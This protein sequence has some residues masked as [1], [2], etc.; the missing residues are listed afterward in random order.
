MK[1][2]I[3]SIQLAKLKLVRWKE[4]IGR[5][6]DKEFLEKSLLKV[7]G[8]RVRDLRCR[9]EKHSEELGSLSVVKIKLKNLETLLYTKERQ[10]KDLNSYIKFIEVNRIRVEKMQEAVDFIN[11]K[12]PVLWKVTEVKEEF[13]R[14]LKEVDIQKEALKEFKFCPLCERSF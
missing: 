13:M 9:V 12:A 7:S 8:D 3:E 14:S 2:R 1:N 5:V 11:F 6:G 10:E 4:M